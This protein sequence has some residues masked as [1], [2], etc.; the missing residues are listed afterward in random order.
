MGVG[1]GVMV[2]L[3]VDVGKMVS[4][5]VRVGTPVGVTAC[6]ALELR[7]TKNTPKSPKKPVIIDPIIIAQG[8]FKRD[9]FGTITSGGGHIIGCEGGA[10]LLSTLRLGIGG[11]SVFPGSR[12]LERRLLLRS[13]SL[14]GSVDIL[15]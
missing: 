5:A 4:T 15:A 8:S 11:F 6:I 2:G 1:V 9:L 14:L 7:I 12:G 13:W 10:T 3:G